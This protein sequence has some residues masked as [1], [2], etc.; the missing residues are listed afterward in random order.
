MTTDLL[1]LI[2]AKDWEGLQQALHTT[3][4]PNDVLSTTLVRVMFWRHL[5][6]VRVLLDAG[7]DPNVTPDDVGMPAICAGAENLWMEGVQLL[8]ERGA[9]INA[10][11]RRAAGWTP[12]MFAVDAAADFTNQ[13][14][15]A[16]SLDLLSFLLSRS[17]DPSARDD[18]GETAADI[19]GSYGW[20]EAV[21]LLDAYA[22]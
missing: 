20:Q 6:A 18:Q 19:A 11:A 12:L 7:A 2:D 16:P 17:A 10:R 9:D 4:Y 1:H 13:G 5:D 22:S 3:V 15:S 21:A 8:V 14:G